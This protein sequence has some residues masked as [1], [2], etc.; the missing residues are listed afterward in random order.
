MTEIT[1]REIA[2]GWLFALAVVLIVAL[3]GGELAPR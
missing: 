2:W 3:L 1:N